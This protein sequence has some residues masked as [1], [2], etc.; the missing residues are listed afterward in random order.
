M[1]NLI[2]LKNPIRAAEGLAD[3]E[4]ALDQD[5]GLLIL[6]RGQGP[7]GLSLD[8]IALPPRSAAPEP[9][10]VVVFG[11]EQPLERVL[12][13][14][15]GG[16]ALGSGWSAPGCTPTGVSTRTASLRLESVIE[17]TRPARINGLRV[18]P[19][20]GVDCIIAFGIETLAGDVILNYDDNAYAGVIETGPDVLLEAGRY[21]LFLESEFPLVCDTL[22]TTCPFVAGVQNH[23]VLVSFA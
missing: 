10:A 12:T 15:G 2:R 18:A 14:G 8:V 16:P 21:V 23:P 13:A 19:A 6:D 20:A 3:G 1:S 7:E 17:I 22:T 11:P 5:E 4:Y 9:D